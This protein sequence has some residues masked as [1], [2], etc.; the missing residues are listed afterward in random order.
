VS[1]LFNNEL[2]ESLAGYS[3]A[4]ELERRCLFVIAARTDPLELE[5]YR[6]AFSSLDKDRD[7]IVSCMDLV[8][9]F[10]AAAR[11]CTIR[12]DAD[13]FFEAADLDCT[14]VINFTKFAAACLHKSLAP[15]DSWLAQQSFECLDRDKDGLL[16]ANQVRPLF[17]KLPAG[18]PHIRSFGLEDWRRCL[19]AS[20]AARIPGR[21][22]EA[23][24]SSEASLQRQSGGR[25]VF[26]SLFNG[27]QTCQKENDRQEA[28]L[29]S[30][31]HGVRVRQ[32]SV[33]LPPPFSDGLDAPLVPT[34]RGINIASPVP[35][36]QH[37][38]HNFQQSRLRQV[39]Y[40]DASAR[41]LSSPTYVPSSAL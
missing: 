14:G 29:H 7:G 40:G 15:L 19:L 22:A 6:L 34:P 24:V 18:L 5:Q 35:S 28:D 26:F 12:V 1:S 8:N 16:N 39:D 3:M 2:M 33:F 30:E 11:F 41:F 13:V 17:G 20:G 9:S 10:R 32:E 27:C 38:T 25:H 4:P 37:A 23:G 21:V 36:P 31:Y